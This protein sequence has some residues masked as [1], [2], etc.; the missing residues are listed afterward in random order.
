MEKSRVS[1][2]P[3]KANMKKLFDAPLLILVILVGLVVLAIWQFYSLASVS[4]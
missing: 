3:E 1:R 2:S 4:P